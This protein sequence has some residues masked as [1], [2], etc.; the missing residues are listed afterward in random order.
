[1]VV[2]GV[3]LKG[4][5]EVA[6][7]SVG[8]SWIEED[9]NQR[10]GVL[11]TLRQGV[12]FGDDGGLVLQRRGDQRVHK[13]KLE[14]GRANQVA[15]SIGKLPSEGIATVCPCSQ[16]RAATRSRSQTATIAP[17]AAV[18]VATMVEWAA[19]ASGVER[20]VNGGAKW[21]PKAKEEVSRV[22]QGAP[23][24]RARQQRGGDSS[25]N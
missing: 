4:E 14:A 11:D 22:T 20:V 13:K 23:C 1:M 6:S 18:R 15:L 21:S 8:R 9:E 25:M 16:A 24:A 10:K 12:A 3:A 2:L 19:A 17:L 5:V 7:A